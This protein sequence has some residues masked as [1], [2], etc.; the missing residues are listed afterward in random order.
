MCLLFISIYKVGF[1]ISNVSYFSCP[2]AYVLLAEEESTTIEEV[3]K[4][5]IGFRNCCKS[6]NGN[7]QVQ[8]PG[9]DSQQH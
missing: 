3:G 8:F 7:I 9:T 1:C 6:L 5:I 2:T 4:Y